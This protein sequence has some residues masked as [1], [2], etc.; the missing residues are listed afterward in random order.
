[1]EVGRSEKTNQIN[2][3][4]QVK[5]NKQ[6]SHKTKKNLF[7][8]QIFSP[9]QKYWLIYNTSYWVILS[10]IMQDSYNRLHIYRFVVISIA[11]YTKD[12]QIRAHDTPSNIQ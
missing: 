5:V 11:S 3:I 9:W 4:Y 7:L 10:F 1:M 12:K 6:D 8:T 2:W